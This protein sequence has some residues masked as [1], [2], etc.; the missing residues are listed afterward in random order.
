MTLTPQLSAEP[1][2]E[3]GP[4]PSCDSCGVDLMHGED[5]VCED[6]AAHLDA[7]DVEADERAVGCWD[8][9]AEE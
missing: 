8:D 5:G 9:A 2:E 1:V 3:G 6:C 7:A 4:P